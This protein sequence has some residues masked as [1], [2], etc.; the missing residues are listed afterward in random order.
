MSGIIRRI[1]HLRLS[2]VRHTVSAYAA[3]AAF[4]V[5][6][7]F[8][9]FVMLV[10]AVLKYFPFTEEEFL[11]LILSLAPATLTDA[12]SDIVNDLYTKHNNFLPVTVFAA[13]WSSSKG[14]Y[15]LMSGMNAVYGQ[16]DSGGYFKRRLN[17][18]LYTVIFITA[19]IFTIGLMLL[20]EWLLEEIIGEFRIRALLTAFRMLT[21]VC[22]LS[23]LFA[24]I[25]YFFPKKRIKISNHFPGA[26]LSAC[27]WVVFTELY[28]V[29]VTFAN[30]DIYGSL[31]TVVLAM[32]WLY[33][34]MYILL[35][36]GEINAYLISQ[37]EVKA[38]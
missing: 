27:G 30:T 6:L 34:C 16:A 31:A 5:L 17:A 37:N 26:F 23:L 4:F 22:V 38:K 8:F 10:M 15:S 12:I 32:L 20:G 33:I 29:Y 21:Q 2:I 25:Y 11:D 3:Q 7:S 18:V 9:P 19:L 13:L 28:S 14:V 35:V 1:N 24:V 36:G